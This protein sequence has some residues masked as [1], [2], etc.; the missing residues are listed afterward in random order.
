MKTKFIVVLFLMVGTIGFSQK[1]AIKLAA[2]ALKSGDMAVAGEALKAAEGQ[3][4]AADQKMK[5][6]FYLL[7][8]QVLSASAGESLEKI[9]E[10]ATAYNKTIEIEKESGAVKYSTEATQKLQLLRQSLI[11]SAIADQNAKNYIGAAEKLYVGYT[12]NK[13][14]TIYLYY[15]A[16]NSIN[17]KNY[18]EALKYYEELK[19]LGFS[20]VKTEFVATNKETGQV[21]PFESKQVRDLSVKSGSYIKPDTRT[22]DS[23]KGEIAKNI[24]LIYMN[25]G[26]DEEAIKAIDDAKKENPEDAALM[27]AEADLYY[28]LGNVAKYKELM[29]QIVAN[30]PENPDLLYNLGVSA[31]RLGDNEQAMEYYKKTLELKSD[32]TAAQINIASMILG[33]ESKIVEEMNG[34]GTSSKDNAR[35]EA[36]KTKRVELYQ[37]AVPYL[38]GALDSKP[39]NIDAVR[40]LMNIYYQLDDPKADEMKN[41]LKSLEGGN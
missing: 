32:Y 9:E 19:G 36:L 24:A 29:E 38:E 23:K 10:A 20:G 7:K 25:Q 41:K 33:G 14:D 15:A 21:E 26:K 5:A 39:D 22:S 11:E 16:G 27:Q 13:L 18:E 1:Q 4:G 6:Q 8:G 31:S 37:S 30:D 17:G 12:T 40:T 35:Y 34:L 2:K 3:L 28:K